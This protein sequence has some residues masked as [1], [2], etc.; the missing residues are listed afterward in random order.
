MLLFHKI[1]STYEKL[2]SCSKKFTLLI[3][4]IIKNKNFDFILK[5]KRLGLLY[6]N[7]VITKEY[8]LNIMENKLNLLNPKAILKNGWTKV[9]K[10]N[11]SVKKIGELNKDDNI[12]IEFLDGVATALIT[13]IKN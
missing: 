9:I 12:K 13:S 7:F 6:N 3:N 10:N 11:K 8:D 2:D 1:D 5:K 4:D